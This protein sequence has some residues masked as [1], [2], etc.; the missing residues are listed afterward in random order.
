MILFLFPFLFPFSD[1][2]FFPS[3]SN[4]A[5]CRKSESRIVCNSKGI[6][7]SD[8]YPER[9]RNVAT[10]YWDS[11]KLLTGSVD[12]SSASNSCRINWPMSRE[13]RNIGNGGSV[14][15]GERGAE[16]EQSGWLS[17]Y[18]VLRNIC[19]LRL[20]VQPFYPPGRRGRLCFRLFIPLHRFR[21]P[22]WL[23]EIFVFIL[24]KP[25]SHFL[26]MDPRSRE[27][28]GLP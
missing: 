6:F 7:T 22:Y 26:S 2:R 16:T 4:S 1:F 20:R 24:Q 14:G 25:S 15:S 18:P 19:N 11:N 9:M 28:F 17:D 8:D 23:V 21:L 5:F 13:K 27:S 10:H 3:K 12:F